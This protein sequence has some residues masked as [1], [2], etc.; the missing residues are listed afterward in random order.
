MK[1]RLSL[2]LGV[3]FIATTLQIQSQTIHIN[4]ILAANVINSPDNVDFDDYS[5]WIELAN[6]S[7]ETVSLDGYYLSDDPDNPLKWAVPAGAEISANGFLVIRADGFDAGPEQVFRREYS[8]WSNFRTTS[9]HTNF[10]LDEEGET[11]SL[12]RVDSTQFGDVDIVSLGSMWRFLDDGGN[13]GPLWAEPGFDDADW[14]EGPAQLGYGESDETTIISYGPDDDDKFP[15]TYFRTRFEEKSPDSLTNV[16]LRML[17][18][19]GA[20]A[21]LNGVEIGRFR[22]DPGTTSYL[23][24]AAD[25]SSEGQFDVISLTP[26][27]L[28][29]GTNVLAVE[30]HQVDADSSDISFDLELV[31]T[32]VPDRF[33]QIDEVN[34]GI[35]TSDV[36]YGRDA[37]GQWTL[38]G[39][40]TPGSA[41]S[42]FNTAD[43]I[44]TSAV[45]FNTSGGF[46]LNEEELHLTT[47]DPTA[48]IHYTLDGSW[49]TSR[50][51][52]YENPI[53][54]STTTVVRARSF[55]PNKVPGEIS[56]HTYFINAPVHEMPIIS[57]AVDPE[58]FFGETL[59]VYANVHK[60]REAPLNL[61]YYEP[62]DK[63][64]FQVNAGVKIGGE[65]IWRFAQKPLNISLRGK[66]G[67]DAIAYQ[68]FPD[69]RM[70]NFSR[71]GLRNGGDNWDDAMLRD[72]ITPRIMHGQMANDVEDYQPVVVYIN[73]RYWGIHNLRS[74]LDPNY[75]A[76]RHQVDPDNYDHLEYGHITSGAVTLG[77][78]EGNTDDYLALEEYAATNDLSDPVHYAHME[79][80]MDMESF[81]DFVC[82]EDFVYN[83]SWRHNREFWRERKDGAK[84]R[85]IVPDLD[86]GLNTSNQTSSLLD[87]FARDFDLFGDLMA[88]ATFKNKLAQRYATHLS[89]TFH[90][91]RIA[92]IVD[93]ANTEVLNEVSRHIDR[94][95]DEDG[96]SSLEDRQEEIDE[97]K[98]FARDRAPHVYSDF[99]DNFG[100]PGTVD[101]TIEVAP[102]NG[103]QVLLN[104]VPLLPNYDST[105]E[106]LEGLPSE[107]T[108]IAAPGY[109]FVEW[110]TGETTTSIDV[111]TDVSWILTATFRQIDESVLPPIIERDLTLNPNSVYTANGH[112]IVP[113]GVTLTIPEGAILRM[114]PLGDLRVSGRLEM[115]G[116]DLNPILVESHRASERWGSIA[117]VDGEG[118][119]QLS[120]VV[121]RGGSLGS[122]P[123]LERGTISIVRSEVEMDHL[124][125]DQ[126]L[127]P[128]FGW[129]STVS[130]RSSRIHTLHTG[131]G[132]NVKHG[133]GLVEDCT[134]PGNTERDTDAIDFDDVT[135]GIIRNNRIYAFR[136]PNSDGI[137]VGEGCVDLLVTGNR[138]FNNSDKGISVGQGSTVRIERNLIVGCAQ[139]IGIKDTGST[140]WINHNS[141]AQCD[142]GVAV[143]EKNLGAGGGIAEVTN[144]IFYRSKD[145]PA[146]VDS[147]SLLTISDSLSDTIPLLGASNR[148]G[149]PEFTDPGIYDFSL[150]PASPYQALG[151]GYVY[152]PSDYPFHVP[153]VIVINEILSHSENGTPDWIELHNTSGN[154]FDLSGWF[155]S[156]AKS[157]LRKYEI[158]D[159]TTIPA[160]GYVVFYENE[161]FG[162][163]SEDP[164]R[165]IPFA[166]NE[167]GE[168]VYLFGPGNEVLLDYVVEES[169]GPSPARVSKGR[170]LKST[171]TYNFVAMSEPTPGETNSTP[172][173]GPIVISEIMYRPSVDGDA[174]YLELVNISNESVTLYDT[175][176]E[177][178]WRFTDGIVFDFPSL[179]PISIGAGERLLL[180][181]NEA[182]FRARF[183]N[184]PET[185][186]VLSWQD[187][188]LSN[189]GERIELSRPGDVDELGV[190]QWVR[191][192][193]VTYGDSVLWPAEADG[194]GLSLTRI[195][196]SA[197]GNDVINWEASP[198]TPGTDKGK[199]DSYDAWANEE[200]IGPFEQDDDGD[201]IL[202]GLEYAL[203][204]N[205]G[206]PSVMPTTQ[207]IISQD[208]L[209]IHIPVVEPR[210][211]VNYSLEISTD[212]LSWQSVET[213]INGR[214]I[215]TTIARTES[216]TRFVRLKVS[217]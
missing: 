146:T 85:W 60:G 183:P 114:P 144:S 208:K 171:Q 206:I 130:L 59:G 209:E 134:F 163:T 79:S 102:T 69:L 207:F 82:I 164:G 150:K 108:A 17:A 129:E 191:V 3:L 139:G 133:E 29:P 113:E 95:L 148:M 204:L 76:S 182:A 64:Q 105:I 14:S 127:I 57:L 185:T 5:D 109:E 149:D 125:I 212:L 45:S 192:D 71:F 145:A 97:I 169:F 90:P 103:G 44:S 54:I 83:S 39:E 118:V 10:K 116:T 4:E 37:D 16:K 211:G 27:Q 216:P 112:V 20:V 96:I 142:V 175:L 22:M 128:I 63:L 210:T 48:S 1:Q 214:A 176:K 198:P 30:V 120:H 199:P 189:G 43:S 203:G 23:S 100:L 74:S 12:A 117:I 194:N 152:D 28:R 40:P 34:F 107:A 166:L 68:L 174:E 143:F 153:N 89:S 122:N 165:H 101:M 67:D 56:T 46:F 205:P 217:Q 168:T 110:S 50:S 93:D 87:N 62:N 11:V 49:P 135:N 157:N 35:Q 47:E 7:D 86:R 136:G 81:M 155:L 24:Y 173:V 36:S 180:V 196:T 38:F 202:N 200:G 51:L 179:A 141:F 94:W 32:R 172:V 126:G 55:A 170:Y 147:L 98:E 177:T 124:D 80:Q 154:P 53:T 115:N 6:P 131:D 9:Y 111:S 26:D 61:A 132:I 84:W 106:L 121:L 190:R 92:D 75:F 25:N 184:T 91:D 197:Y 104:D 77:V 73:G 88:N 156:D 13:P 201:G 186:L 167:N 78:K 162:E 160:N 193:R 18:D 195:E 70:A 2:P 140:A 213:S 158:A 215:S 41:N 178:P 188:G 181:R 123:A 33:E 8:P 58:I 138:I 72:A 119:S 42:A 151:A 137:D 21:F 52:V 99:Q 31:A 187:S 65:N 159:G 15:T 66:Y 161:T 19:D